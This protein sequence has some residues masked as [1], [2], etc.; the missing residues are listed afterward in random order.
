M[1]PAAAR[2]GRGGARAASLEAG[3]IPAEFGTIS[4]GEDLMKPTAMLYRNLLAIEIEEMIRGQPAGRDRHPGQLRQDGAGR[5]HGRGQRGHPHR[6][7]HRRRPRRPPSSAGERIGTG[8][9]LWRLWD[10]RRTGP[11]R[12]RR[13][14][15]RW[16]RCLACGTG[17]L[18]HDGHRLHDG[19]DGRGAGADDPGVEHDPGRRPARR[20]PPR[21]RR[22]GARSPRSATGLAPSALLSPAAFGN[23]IRVLHAVGGSTN[24]VIHL[25]AIAGRVGVGLPLDDLARL[26]AGVP[27]LADVQPSGAGLMQD[28][29][30]AGGPARPAAR[31]VR[32]ARRRRP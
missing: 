12:R 32:A 30:A 14:A 27:V 23:A 20:R 29:D 10:E 17:R 7:G 9:A 8:T 11:A 24:A 2:A 19:A 3:G 26:G 5:D 1:Q 25:A 18:Q 22:A 15:G 4:L 13:L 16:R 6:G 21:P 31:A 28:F